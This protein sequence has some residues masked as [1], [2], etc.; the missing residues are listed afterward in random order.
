M[1]AVY[2]GL[3]ILFVFTDVLKETISV[4]R[5]QFG[6]VLLVYAAIRTFMTIRKIKREKINEI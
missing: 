6:I 2:V 5:V 4:Y 3:G 1:I